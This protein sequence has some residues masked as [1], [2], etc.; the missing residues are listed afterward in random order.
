MRLIALLLGTC[1]TTLL[2]P[3]AGAQEES[4]ATSPAAHVAPAPHAK[5]VHATKGPRVDRNFRKALGIPDDWAGAPPVASLTDKKRTLEEITPLQQRVT[6]L[7]GASPEKAAEA[8]VRLANALASRGLD[9]A[10]GAEYLLA[11][12]LG[13]ESSVAYN[14]LGVVL[15]R[16]GALEEAQEATERAIDLAPDTGL[17]WF[18]LGIILEARGKRKAAEENYLRA[19][20]LDPGLWLSSNNPGVVGNALARRAVLARYMAQGGP[21]GD[22]L[23]QLAPPAPTATR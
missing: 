22:R 3:A 20:E 18:N 1:A 8:H 14:N 21:G 9:Q 4:T 11:L 23:D 15:R 7:A 13:G 16:A 2:V 5:P 17:A 6:D 19:L 10:A 12:G